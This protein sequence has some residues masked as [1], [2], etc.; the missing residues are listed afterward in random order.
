M[1]LVKITLLTLL[2][3]SLAGCSKVDDDFYPYK[4]TGLNS[5]VYDPATDQE[6]LAG[7]TPAN[8][9]NRESALAVCAAQASTAAAERKI[10]NWSYVCCTVT[11]ESQCATKVR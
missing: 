7:F 8:Y 10:D 1:R 11:S 4:M 2:A 3:C 6:Y 9:K 5:W